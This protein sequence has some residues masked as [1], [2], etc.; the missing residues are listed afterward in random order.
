MS[1]VAVILAIVGK[2]LR[3]FAR[4]KLWLVLTPVSVLFVVAAFWLAPSTVDDKVALGVFPPDAVQYLTALEDP[5]EEG[6]AL[7][8]FDSEEALAEAISGEILVGMVFP[9]DFLEA[10]AADRPTQATM[11][12][13][14]AVP[15]A[16]QH[17]F[18]SEV[19]EI[20]WAVQGQVKYGD[21]DLA[22]P[23]TLPDEEV[24][25]LGEDRAGALVPM[26]E[27]LRPMLAIL[28]LML[29]SIAL[30][31][32]VAAE[33]EK[34]TVTAILVTPARVA[35]LLAAKAITGTLI[36]SVQG[37]LFLVC[38]W[39]V[40]GNVLVVVLLMLLGA[41]MMASLG[42]L[43]GAAGK[44]F[45]TTMFLTIALI[46]PMVVPTFA[47][48]FPGR[49]PLWIQLMPAWGF[50]ESMV[51]VLGYGRSPAEL[52]LPIGLTVV[53]TIAL[54]AVA[55]MVLRRRVVAL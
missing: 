51:G 32:L 47:V 8:P 34:R 45:M 22:L 30:A 16:L 37:L 52:W 54:L 42:L 3:A 25:V 43:A 48:L 46:L 26:R 2:D 5:S 53:W 35:D 12:I 13:D 4:D 15:E 28:M 27:K 14:P 50:V 36:G 41:L 23:V 49:T 6:I 33:I 17:A 9:A 20:G 7:I 21:P 39:S 24:M 10:L 31:G 40:G 11:W 38:T 19:R 29:G 44:D 18:A 1:R 55:L